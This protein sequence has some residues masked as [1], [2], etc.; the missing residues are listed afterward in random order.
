L[1]IIKRCRRFGK[2]VKRKL[3]A[4]CS[5][6]VFGLVVALAGIAAA[7]G[8]TGGIGLQ[9]IEL[10][11]AGEKNLAKAP[12]VTDQIAKAIVE[13]R[14]AKG[15]F[16]KPEDLLKVPGI[17]KEVYQKMKA[18]VG[19]EGDLY[20]LPREGETLEQEGEEPPPLAP[21]KC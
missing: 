5:V 21:S 10:N 1:E 3:I 2:M 18:T 7:Q 19:P 11:L 9:K 20:V 17:T 15:P 4:V 12:G 6:V 8:H 14:N 13:Y 16:K